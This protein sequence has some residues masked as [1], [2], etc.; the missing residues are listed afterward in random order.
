MVIS[1]TFVWQFWSRDNKDK[2][3]ENAEPETKRATRATCQILKD[4]EPT[5]VRS[6]LSQAYIFCVRTFCK[7]VVPPPL[8]ILTRNPKYLIVN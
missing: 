5:Q 2:G 6:P 1:K 3:G 8:K 4:V 7:P